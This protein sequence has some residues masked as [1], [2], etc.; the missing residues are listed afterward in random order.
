[1]AVVGALG[2]MTLAAMMYTRRR[3]ATVSLQ[4]RNE[5]NGLRIG[6]KNR[7]VSDWNLEEGS[8]RRR[9]CENAAPSLDNLFISV[10]KQAFLHDKPGGMSSSSCSSS[11]RRAFNTKIQ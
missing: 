7:S 8:D 11:T 2:L 1:M 10:G 4:D 9:G 5:P 6:Y 3:K